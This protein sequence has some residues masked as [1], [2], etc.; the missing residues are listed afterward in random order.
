MRD[1]GVERGLGRL[2]FGRLRAQ[3]LAGVGAEGRMFMWQCGSPG[4]ALMRAN[5]EQLRRAMIDGHYITGHEID[6]D[7]AQLEDPAFMMPSAIMW[8]AWGSR[9]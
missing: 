9:P 8:T 5:F 1:R 6:R 3:G 7:L 4:T 2:L